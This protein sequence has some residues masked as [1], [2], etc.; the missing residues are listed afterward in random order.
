VTVKLFW[1]INQQRQY[2]HLKRVN[3]KKIKCN[4]FLAALLLSTAASFATS[5]QTNPTDLCETQP[6]NPGPTINGECPYRPDL[7]CCQLARGSASQ[8]VTQFQNGLPVKIRRHPTTQ[9]TIFGV[10]Q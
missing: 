10:R 7:V 9:V 2:I 1:L 4:Y 5:S 6:G 8:Y 3:M